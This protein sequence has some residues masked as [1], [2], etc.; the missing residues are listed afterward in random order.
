[1]PAIPLI[2]Y[3]LGGW[4]LAISG[5]LILQGVL[6]AQCAHYISLY[7]KNIQFLRVYVNILLIVTT[8]KSA[9]LLA[10]LWLQ[11]VVHFTDSAEAAGMVNTAW[12]A[13][14]NIVFVALIAFYV[15]LFPC[16]RLW[17]ISRNIYIV[18]LV[19]ALFLFG[20]VASFMA[21]AT[22]GNSEMARRGVRF[23]ERNYATA[24]ERSPVAIHLAIVF[25]GDLLLCANTT[26]FLLKRLKQVLPQTAGMLNAVVKLTFQSAAPAALCT[27]INLVCSQSGN[28]SAD[29]NGWTM[30]SLISNSIMPKLYAISAMWVDAQL[31]Q[32]HPAR[33]KLECER[34]DDEQRRGAERR[35]AE[36]AQ[37]DE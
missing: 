2:T 15:Q 23:F 13:V 35:G 18:V 12:P 16:Q 29:A 14:Y 8:L 11:N 32:G 27:L 3:I 6:F 22:R 30:G 34:A 10:I 36:W 4:D 24:Y 26:Y 1:M 19:A 20:L 37:A 5:D 17:V 7:I 25:A 31:A 28:I 21:V 9:Q 33:A